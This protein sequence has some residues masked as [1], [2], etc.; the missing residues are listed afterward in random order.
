MKIVE[1]ALKRKVKEYQVRLL[2]SREDIGCVFDL[3]ESDVEVKTYDAEHGVY[4]E[5][6]G[7][8]EDVIKAEN[9]LV[10]TILRKHRLEQR[11]R[12]MAET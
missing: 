5:V 11:R 3:R 9:H 2:I 10:D 4:V 7:K 6:K 1:D 12:E 8:A